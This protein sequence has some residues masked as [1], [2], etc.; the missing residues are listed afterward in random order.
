MMN[1]EEHTLNVGTVGHVLHKVVIIGG[2]SAGNL[3]IYTSLLADKG[4][5]LIH[6]E[7][8]NDLR[9]M[10]YDQVFMDELND[11]RINRIVNLRSNC[12]FAK[13]QG[14]S[15]GHGKKYKDWELR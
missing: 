14:R 13:P 1:T 9:G 12:V 11:D 4:I 2:N 8:K 10:E 6:V 7:D 15:R 3:S 5:Q